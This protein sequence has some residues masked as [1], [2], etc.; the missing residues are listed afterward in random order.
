MLERGDFVT[1]WLNGQP[2][3]DKPIL[4]YWLQA[5]SVSLF[6]VHEFAFRLPS[7]L[8]GLGWVGAILAFTRQ[9]C[10]PRH[11]LCRRADRRHHA[12]RR[13]DR[14]RRH[15]RRLAQPVPRAG[16]VRHLPLHGAAAGA[17]PPPRLAVDGARPADQRAGRAADSVR[18]QRPGVRAARQGARLAPGRARPGRLADPAGGGRPLVPAR[19]PA[20][21]R[22][23]H[24]RL[25]PAPQRR[26]L[27][28]AAAGA[29]R[30][31][32]S[33]TCRRPCC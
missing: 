32:C 19:I 33:I 27:H 9:Q 28:V 24:R 4:T 3:F 11:R 18:R 20:P 16:H 22:R 6:G 5:L 12:G 13:R 8:A 7:A 1:T 25:L 21:G 26:A 31:P 23:L 29:P 30:Q 15:R 17:L 14:A 2:R 10:R